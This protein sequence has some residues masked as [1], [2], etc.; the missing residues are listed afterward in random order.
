MQKLGSWL[1]EKGLKFGIYADCGRLTCQEYPGSAGF[2]KLDA[3][4]FAKWGVDMVKLDGCY[5]ELK[6]FSGYYTKWSEAL[7]STGRDI[8]FSC[9]WPAYDPRPPEEFPYEHLRKLCNMWRVYEDIEPSW[10]SLRRIMNYWRVHQDRLV[11]LVRPGNFNDPDMLEIGNGLLTKAEGQTQMSI[12][13]ILAAPL[14]LGNDLTSCREEADV[15]DIIGNEQVIAIDQDIGVQQGRWVTKRNNNTQELWVRPL[16]E[17]CNQW[18][19]TNTTVFLPTP[20]K[21]TTDADECICPISPK[22]GGGVA[23]ALI[24]LSNESQK[25]SFQFKEIFGQDNVCCWSMDLWEK[26]KK[27]TF[28][29]LEVHSNGTV[30]SH[31]TFMVKL[32]SNKAKT[33]DNTNGRIKFEF[34]QS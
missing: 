2:E 20:R 7:Q 5:A 27:W 15:M 21:S 29:R 24:N 12:W 31:G 6:D 32:R 10:K 9:S 3:E 8:V 13:S 11:E 17:S 19:N 14:L 22:G 34:L 18:F 1:H 4:T 16:G 25:M 28:F 33:S 30:P 26:E 23:V